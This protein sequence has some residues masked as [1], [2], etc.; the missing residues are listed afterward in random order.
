M[1][2]GD[3][4]LI[5]GPAEVEAICKRLDELAPPGTLVQIRDYRTGRVRWQAPPG[6]KKGQRRTNIH[7]YQAR[8]NDDEHQRAGQLLA[9]GES[10]MSLTRRLILAG[11]ETLSKSQDS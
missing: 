1:L 3:N 7:V 5:V 8:L 11:L 6:G 9:E 2:E 4:P 10:N